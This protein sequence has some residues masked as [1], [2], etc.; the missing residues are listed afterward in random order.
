[1]MARASGDAVEEPVVGL[2]GDVVALGDREP[3]VGDDLGLGP[4]LVADPADADVLDGLDAGHAGQHGV[5]RSTRSGS[6][7]S[8]SRR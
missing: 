5:H 6:T 3:A 1:M 4:Q 2:F 7:L 8:M